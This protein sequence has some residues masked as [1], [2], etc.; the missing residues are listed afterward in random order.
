MVSAACPKCKI[1]LIATGGWHTDLAEANQVAISM[2]ADVIY[3]AW[4]LGA[5]EVTAEKT[6][7]ELDPYLSHPSDVTI[8]AAAGNE[9]QPTY[10]GTSTKVVTVGGTRLVKANNSRGWEE[11]AWP[12]AGSGCSLFQPKPAW[13]ADAGCE[14]RA[15]ADVAAV[16]DPFSSV[17]V[18]SSSNGGWIGAGGTSAAAPLI[19]GHL[20]T[21]SLSFREAA[22]K[23]FYDAARNHEM[24]DVVFGLNKHC[25]ALNDYPESYLCEGSPGYDGPTGVGT[26]GTPLPGPPSNWRQAALLEPES[27][28]LKG[29]INPQGKA[30]TYQFE[31]GTTT[32]YG[33]SVP[34]SPASAGNGVE[35]VLVSQRLTGLQPGTQYHYRLAATNSTGTYYDIGSFIT[36]PTAAQ[37]AVSTE[38]ATG[39]GVGTATLNGAIEAVAA[40]TTY[41][42]EYGPTTSYGSI[43]PAT[44]KSVGTGFT[45]VSQA[46][47]GL[48]SDRVYHFRI[49]ATQGSEVKYGRDYVFRTPPG[50][51]T[52]ITLPLTGLHAG[53]GR[54]NGK[55][56]AGGAETRYG[57][58]ILS[59]A[60]FKEKGFAA[61]LPAG[62]GTKITGSDLTDVSFGFGGLQEEATYHYRLVAENA[63]GTTHGQIQTLTTL[64]WRDENLSSQPFPWRAALRGVSCTAPSACT[65]VG[66]NTTKSPP[67]TLAVRKTTAW[68]IQAT[69]NPT[70]A[71][72]SRLEDVSCVTATLCM[73]VGSYLD[74]AGVRQP[75]AERW[76][77]S[78]WTIVATPLPAGASGGRLDGVSCAAADICSA[79]GSYVNASGTHLALAE[80]WA[81]GSW[82]LDLPQNPS[83]ATRAI[84]RDVSCAGS[85]C[86][87]VGESEEAGKASTALVERRGAGGWTIQALAEPVASLSAVDCASSSW[88]AAV[89]SGLHVQHWNGTGWSDRLAPSPGEGGQLTGVSCTS[90][91]SCTAVGTYAPGHSVPFAEHWGGSEW[92]L[93]GMPDHAD[94]PFCTG[95]SCIAA[96]NVDDVACVPGRCSAV[97]AKTTKD[98]AVTQLIERHVAQKPRVDYGSPTV[99]PTTVTLRGTV[100]A[101]GEDTAYRFEYDTAEYKAGEAP[102]GS[103]VPLS[104]KAIG[105]AF[106]PVA[107]SQQL[108]RPAQAGTYHYRLVAESAAG[109]TYGADRTFEVHAPR[110]Q[111]AQY[112]AT[113]SGGQKSAYGNVLT[114]E[115]G[116]LEC[117][118]ATLAGQL[119]A[120]A[121]TLVLSPTYSEC[122][123][124][125]FS[126]ATVAANGCTYQMA[127]DG[128]FWAGDYPA[129]LAISCPAGK[130]VEVT[131]GNCALTIGAQ[132]GL[133][134]VS[135]RN[136]AAASPRRVEVA[137]GVANLKYTVTKDGLACPFSGTGTK[138]GGRYSGPATLGAVNA[139]QTPIDLELAGVEVEAHA[140]RFESGGYPAVL[141][142]GQKSA[143]GNVLTTEAGQLECGK[144]TLAGQLGAAANTLVLSP[145]YSECKAF[146]FSSATVTTNGCTYQVALAGTKSGD[147]YP[148]T[149]GIACPEGKAIEIVANNCTVAI[150]AQSGLG[151]VNVS[152]DTATTPQRLEVA[153]GVAK[154]KYTVTKDGFL[155]P[156]AG[157]GTKEGGYSGPATISAANAL[158]TPLGLRVG[159]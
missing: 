47:S 23:S 38:S 105:S 19:A 141:S 150:G 108:G 106:A 121:N 128:T 109:T 88:C 66:T 102:H 18:Y 72:E 49:K 15:V 54:F 119:G 24:Y 155:C 58:Q 96:S 143:Y 144:A 135:A 94:N 3:N 117:G 36:T 27:V 28:M 33:S 51:P 55:V 77:G 80:R 14:H 116:Q 101:R 129:A 118:K 89:G 29:A 7:R 98:G 153:F 26:P 5:D 22:P 59:D 159:E 37:F 31:Y 86:W 111:A 95:Q 57:F 104:P 154:L 127:L 17:S 48:E 142:G 1:L 9:P 79:V 64:G 122:K 156:F 39:V 146:G 107:V 11:I 134:T 6:H 40:G 25:S 100:D 81:E 63:Y 8:V 152:N 30:T 75:L 10:P 43:A 70:G 99:D 149:M 44:P 73:A 34:A 148:G 130:A 112:P 71:T 42:F 115:A 82:S 20:A 131:A 139:S 2:G 125:G 4:Y 92:Q 110:F 41:Q 62:A 140:P 87:A 60:E 45:A 68:Q 56:A 93:R 46:L 53:G 137:F 113:L 132:S 126:S 76:D 136:E 151:T 50:P 158:K 21:K 12:G 16:A 78:E 61:S 138:E 124:F 157:T 145:T 74:G 103:S 13:Q 32:S 120:A 84:L 91:T 65:A 52:A 133:G 147:K 90:A 123:A 35:A 69:P 97:G 83:G 67:T 114:T 85:E